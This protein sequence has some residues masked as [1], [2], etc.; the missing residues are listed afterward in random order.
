[1]KKV[2]I[3][4]LGCKT[5]SY[6][7]ALIISSFADDYE[8]VD[9][10]Q[11]ADIYIINTCTVTGRTDYKSRN[12]IR[13]ALKHKTANPQIR[14][15]VTG[16]YSQ[17]H[18]QDVTALGSI[19]EVVDNQNKDRIRAILAGEENIFSDAASAFEY[20]YAPITSMLERSRA[21]Q[22]IQDGCG[23]FCS[24]CAVSH[25]R[26]PSRSAT[27]AEVLEQARLFVANGYAE[28]VLG[29][30]NLGL[31]RD[32]NT[33]LAGLIPHL[34]EVEGLQLLRLSSM[35]PH[36]F[37]DT[38][39]E[40][41]AKGGIACPH[42]HLSLQSGSDRILKSMKRRYNTDDIQRLV[43]KI[44]GAMPNAAIGADIITGYPSESQADFTQSLSL[45]RELPLAY[46]HVFAYSKRP[47]TP[48]A[49]MPKQI[50]AA[51]KKE[52]S[53]QLLKLSAQKTAAYT[54][55]II[56]RKVPL[57]GI[58]EAHQDRYATFTSDHYIRGYTADTA[59]EGELIT[60]N[61]VST[62]KD[63]LAGTIINT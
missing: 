14:I 59:R 30:V 36:L 56:D 48:A 1:M 4:T 28:I 61:P 60:I 63:G 51:I 20:R 11:A 55:Q 52:R 5:N 3:A 49:E 43:Q 22:K 10:D 54:G 42:F 46:L 31:Y 27:V 23:L 57:R 33:D 8:V 37:N 32:R 21:F 50:P 17:R 34:R 29:G 18:P 44:L 19:D 24:Y 13:K 47:G 16:C 25:A 39:I 26:G 53:A 12:L 38:L 62:H 35:E 40:E 45:I 6:E 41:M 15:V 9:F 7:S 58:V 2:A